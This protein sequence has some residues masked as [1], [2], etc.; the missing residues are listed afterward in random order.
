[1]SGERCTY[2]YFT[3]TCLYLALNISLGPDFHLY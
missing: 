1:M 3:S 2:I